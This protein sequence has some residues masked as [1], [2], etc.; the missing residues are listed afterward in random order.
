MAKHSKLQVERSRV[1]AKRSRLQTAMAKHSKL[2]TER[3]RLQA[4]QSRLQA[5][6]LRPATY[7]YTNE[8]TTSEGLGRRIRDV[9]GDVCGLL[10]SEK[11]KRYTRESTTS[12]SWP[13]GQA[14]GHGQWVL[15]WGAKH[16]DSQ[17]AE[18]VEPST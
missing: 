11:L 6:A 13:S 17:A 8:S 7:R 18:K 10:P 15:D 1:Q 16:S 14:R 2:Q 4:E 12:P 9:C 5:A 3:S